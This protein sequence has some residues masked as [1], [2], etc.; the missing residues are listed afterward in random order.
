MAIFLT[1]LLSLLSVGVLAGRV[2]EIL[3]LT[4]AATGFFYYKGIVFN[5]Y[6]LGIF[7]VIAICCGV[8]IFGDKKD[9]RPFFSQSSKIIS[10]AAGAM[11]VVYSVMSYSSSFNFVFTLA[12]GLGLILLGVFEIHPKG[13]I[14]D[15][16]ITVLMLVFIIGKSLDVI[17][18]DVYTIHNVQFIKN[19]LSY[20]STGLFFMYVFKNAFA[21]SKT[22]R[23]LLYITGMLAALMCGIMNIAEIVCMAINDSIV[24]PDLFFLAGYA[25]LGFFAFDNAVSVLPKK[26]VTGREEQEED[27]D[28]KIYV[29]QNSAAPVVENETDVQHDT[30][31]KKEPSHLQE[32]KFDLSR[33]EEFTQFFARLE[34][35]Q[36]PHN[37]TEKTAEKQTFKADKNSGKK[38]VYK[39]PK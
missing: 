29:S 18:F 26:S 12:G 36:E 5:P 37:K 6:I 10:I 13:D 15:I 8:I 33:N 11:F 17:I 3:N 7:A 28:V 27:T 19:A 2:Y 21:P 4:D 9:D 35:K 31:V 24:L 30:A 20:I 34:E 16:L 23:M 1:I 39:K 38:I 25:F 32:E 22:S 14:K